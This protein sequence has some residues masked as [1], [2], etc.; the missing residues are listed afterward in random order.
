LRKFYNWMGETAREQVFD[1]L[2]RVL[3]DPSLTLKV[4]AYDLNEPD[5]VKI[6]LTLSEQGRVR[7]ILD[8]ASLH[9]TQKASKVKTPEDQ[10]TDLFQQRK[11]GP[12]DILRG[13]FARYSHDKIFIVSRDRGSAIQ[14]LTGSTNFSLKGLYVNANHVLVFQ[15]ANVAGQ[16]DE[17][18]EKSWQVL[19]NNKSPSKAAAAA[20]SN[21]NL[22]TQPYNSQAGF[23]PKMNITFSPHTP[24]DVNKILDG[25]SNRI[26]QETHSAKGNVLFAVMQLTG[27]QSPVYKTLGALHATQSVYSYGISDAPAGIFLYSPA[28][29]S[30]VQVTGR[31]GQVT[32]PEKSCLG[33]TSARPGII[34][35]GW[36]GVWV[37]VFAMATAMSAL[38]RKADVTE[39]RRH[40]RL[41]PKA[42]SCTAA[43]SLIRSPRRSA[44]R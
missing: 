44:S 28:Q 10:F 43:N 26:M 19:N 18:F 42:D 34:V 11:K 35:D 12:S 9:V 2:N 22:A 5:I 17:V 21:T 20:F 7:I 29:A 13:S 41:V 30:V 40:V 27:S 3:N 36:G 16:Y 33:D 39:I 23:V 1:L 15:D 8:D 24:A 38:P 4:F 37:Q 31:P 14:V 32:L 6:L 25:I